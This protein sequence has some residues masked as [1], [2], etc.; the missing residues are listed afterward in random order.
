[1][2]SRRWIYGATILLGAF[3]LF[4]VQPLLSRWILPWFGGGTAVWTTCMLFFQSV[5]FAGYAYAHV[6]ERTPAS[7]RTLVHLALLGASLLVLPLSPEEAWKPEAGGN[8]TWP[9]LK[10]LGM[11]VGLPCLLLSSTGP[12][13]QAWAARSAPGHSPYRLYA[14]SNIGSLTALLS[15]P[16]LVEPHAGLRA[17][18]RI[19]TWAFALYS[20]LAAAGVLL[21]RRSPP[22]GPAGEDEEEPGPGLRSVWVLLPAAASALLL[23]TTNQLGQDI[24]VLPFLWV[25]P[26]A[27]YLISF[28]IVFDR[29]AWYRPELVAPATVLFTFG[30]AVAYYARP[31]SAL[32][33]SMAIAIHL[34]ALLGLCLLCHGELARLKPRPGRLTGYY[35]AIAAG[36]AAGG[37]LVSLVAPQVFSTFFEW[38]LGMGLSYAAAWFASAWIYRGYFRAHPNIAAILVVVAGLG[39]AFQ[40][41]LLSTYRHLLESSRTFYGAV[42]VEENAEARDMTNGRVLHGRQYTD[43]KRRR[44]PN[45]YYVDGSGVGLALGRFRGR[46]DLR[47][48]VVG[49]GVGTLA[50]YV[51]QPTQSIRFYEI[52]P[53][54]PRIAKQWFTYLGDC[55]GRVEIALGDARLSLEREPPQG[56]HVLALDAFSGHTVPT[57][58]LTVEAMKIWL[59]H[60]RADGILAVHVSNQYLRLGPVVRGAAHHCGLKTL[61][62]D[63]EEDT[64]GSGLASSWM[65]CAR[66]DETLGDLGLHAAPDGGGADVVW[67]DDESDLFSILRPRSRP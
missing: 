56:F 14:L 63:K 54:V 37:L 67:T 7:A 44:L 9:I 47:I 18:A 34:G 52:N 21:D 49:L 48:G 45:T 23:A 43:P 62:V 66:T 22:A 36:G 28:I 51:V 27:V 59:G 55:P 1:M 2:P 11:T 32:A 41:A 6:S 10:L 35:L 50:T 15:Y 57:H 61:R 17:Q 58:L 29:P 12:L 65:L 8:P 33:L 38:K 31:I 26:L 3:L 30:A 20:A 42:A 5:L 40:V 19:W 24:A 25:L 60:L 4:Q 46:P 39:F 64:K 13:V 16:F 53:E